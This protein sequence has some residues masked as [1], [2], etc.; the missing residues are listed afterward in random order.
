MRRKDYQMNVAPT[1]PLVMPS[2]KA[3]VIQNFSWV[4]RERREQ[5]AYFKQQANPSTNMQGS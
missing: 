4:S 5:L 1:S 3:R 2:L